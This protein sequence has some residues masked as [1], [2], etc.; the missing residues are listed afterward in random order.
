MVIL[1]SGREMK[2]LSIL[3]CAL[4]LFSCSSKKG[5]EGVLKSYIDKRFSS[6]IEKDDFSD[7]FG[8]EMLDDLETVDETVVGK[9]NDIKGYKKKSLEINFKKCSQEKCFL[10]Y[11]LVFDAKAEA[12]STKKNVAVKVKKI[13]ELQKTGETWKIFDISDVKTHY[14]YK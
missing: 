2:L 6:G 9:M 11:T 3:M 8:G 14:D 1:T 7:Y 13:A 4:V 12:G 10:T 5:P